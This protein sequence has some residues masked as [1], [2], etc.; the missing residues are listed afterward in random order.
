MSRVYIPVG[1]VVSYNPLV[2]ENDTEVR[3]GT[4]TDLNYGPPRCYTVLLDKKRSSSE[5]YSRG[6]GIEARGGRVSNEDYSNRD[7]YWNCDASGLTQIKKFNGH[8]P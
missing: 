7:K 5:A 1:T 2:H 4:I 3:I 6:W 8:K